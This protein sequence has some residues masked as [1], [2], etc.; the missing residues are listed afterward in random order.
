MSHV[1]VNL[2]KCSKCIVPFCTCVHMCDQNNSRQRLSSLV[3]RPDPPPVLHYC[4][5]NWT[6]GMDYSRCTADFSCVRIFHAPY[7]IPRNT[8]S[9]GST[10]A[11]VERLDCVFRGFPYKARKIQTQLKSAVTPV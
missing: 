9:S 10:L 1:I 2:Y 3:Y 5:K 6:G 8:Q 11:T 7:R 4:N